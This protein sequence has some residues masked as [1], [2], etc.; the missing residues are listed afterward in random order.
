MIDI[1]S[2]WY[3]YVFQIS[4][5]TAL[6]RKNETSGYDFVCLLKK[7]YYLILTEDNWINAKHY[8]SK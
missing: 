2:G 6:K 1:F 3:I 5:P 4:V 8:S 7:K